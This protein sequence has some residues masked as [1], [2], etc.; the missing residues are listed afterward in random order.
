M[1]TNKYIPYNDDNVNTYSE[2]RDNAIVT[3]FYSC[4]NVPNLFSLR[5]YLHVNLVYC[6]YIC[7]ILM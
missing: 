5:I 7:I 6:F 2:E 1:I 3:V 4:I